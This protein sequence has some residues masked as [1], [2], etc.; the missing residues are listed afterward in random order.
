MQKIRS[1]LMR[2]QNV[3]AFVD[4][5][6]KTIYRTCAIIAT[7]AVVLSVV[8]LS[9]NNYKAA[10]KNKVSNASNVLKAEASVDDETD[11]EVDSFNIAMPGELAADTTE[12]SSIT[13]EV[14][15]TA[16][17]NEEVVK[18]ELSQVTEVEPEAV[19]NQVQ[20]NTVAAPV[21]SSAVCSYTAEEYEILLRIVEAE[22]GGCDIIGKILVANVIVNRVN[23]KKFPNNIKDVVFAPT[24]F[25][26]IAD[27]RYYTVKVSDSTRE[28]VDRALKGEDYSQGALYF[29]STGCVAAGQCWAARAMRTLFEHDGH[30]FFAP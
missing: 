20:V 6:T 1:Y 23:Y 12:Q 24:Q 27:G 30:V 22:A 2:V 10:G 19:I 7:G 18:I 9:S 26:P 28:A 8:S 16:E 17:N 11:I 15:L 4:S 3:F 5:L 29:A 14:F 25:S 13:K 21:F